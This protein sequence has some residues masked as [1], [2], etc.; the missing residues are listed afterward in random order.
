M[1]MQSHLAELE[2]R[3]NARLTFRSDPTFYRE[4]VVFAD[5]KTGNEITD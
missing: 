4:Q 3:H 2:R 5:A 1:S